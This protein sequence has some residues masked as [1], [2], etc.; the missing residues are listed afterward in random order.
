VLNSRVPEFGFEHVD[1]P[2]RLASVDWSLP[3]ILTL[4]L[5]A[6][7]AGRRSLAQLET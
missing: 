7:V 4:V 5:T 2:R 1:D 3:T 6:I